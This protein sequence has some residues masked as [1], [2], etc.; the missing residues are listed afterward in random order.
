MPQ[1]FRRVTSINYS[2]SESSLR[3]SKAGGVG[4][5]EVGTA[6]DVRTGWLW[7]DNRYGRAASGLSV[8]EDP[9]A[10]VSTDLP[11]PTQS[12]VRPDTRYDG[13]ST[14]N[15]I[16]LHTSLYIFYPTKYFNIFHFYIEVFTIDIFC[17]RVVFDSN[18]VC[19]GV[20]WVVPG[21]LGDCYTLWLP[22]FLPSMS[23]Q[24]YYSQ[25]IFLILL[26]DYSRL[27]LL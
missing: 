26:R 1:L 20:S 4:R 14:W 15:D 18:V 12:G 10:S 24:R 2:Q 9:L 6:G 8:R 7:C 11:T 16:T 22:F 17:L 25:S 21:L 27:L 23:L 3:P 13:H 19:D 5:V